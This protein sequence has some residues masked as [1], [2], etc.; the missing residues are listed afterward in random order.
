V[1]IVSRLAVKS[2]I[3]SGQLAE[4]RLKGVKLQRPIYHLR[5][6]RRRQSKAAAAFLGIVLR[7]LRGNVAGRPK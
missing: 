6:R 3:K 5:E 4:I 7:E 1:A 2:E